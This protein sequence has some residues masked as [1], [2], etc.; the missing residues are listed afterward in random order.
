MAT[1]ITGIVLCSYSAVNI[2]KIILRTMQYAN[3]ML[4]MV[5]STFNISK[6]R[7]IET[8]EL[9]RIKK[10][11]PTYVGPNSKGLNVMIPVESSEY[12]EKITSI[13]KTNNGEKSEIMYYKVFANDN[14]GTHKI[15]PVTWMTQ[16]Q[17]DKLLKQFDDNNNYMRQTTENM[18]NDK[19]I[20][21]HVTVPEGL[22][23]NFNNKTD[24]E[25]DTSQKVLAISCAMSERLPLTFISGII[26]V[27]CLIYVN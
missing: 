21:K 16:N 8:L 9:H 3:D 14:V 25:V 27:L 26:G 1:T 12:S 23:L 24:G 11:S 18:S 5:R 4:P 2:S 20:L 7:N 22:V 13:C 6:H 17:V 10:D 15:V 19:L